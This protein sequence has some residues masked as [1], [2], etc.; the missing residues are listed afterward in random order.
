M[1]LIVVFDPAPQDSE[2]VAVAATIEI[3]FRLG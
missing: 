3:N 1:R 2:L